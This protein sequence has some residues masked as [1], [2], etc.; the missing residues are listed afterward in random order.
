MVVLIFNVLY[1]V[2]S[3]NSFFVSLTAVKQYNFSAVEFMN[4]RIVPVY[5][6]YD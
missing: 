6:S 4:M 1:E 3:P 2:E 5:N